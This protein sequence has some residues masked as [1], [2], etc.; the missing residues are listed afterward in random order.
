MDCCWLRGIV[1]LGALRRKGGESK[2]GGR[3]IYIRQIE[4]I[5]SPDGLV[6]ITAYHLE[7]EG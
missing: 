4:A 3:T 1:R 7:S 2:F 5:Y 6:A